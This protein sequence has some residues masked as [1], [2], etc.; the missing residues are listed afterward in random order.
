V[1]EGVIVDLGH[2]PLGQR[3]PAAELAANVV[4]EAVIVHR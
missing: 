3:A 4:E 1:K 2:R